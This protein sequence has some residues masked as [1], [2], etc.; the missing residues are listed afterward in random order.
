MKILMVCLGNICRSPLAQ[1]IME[2]IIASRKL[3]WTV[4]S[5]GTSGWHNGEQ[6]DVRAMAVAKRHGIDIS[7]QRSRKMTSKDLTVFDIILTMD[8][9]NYN[10]VL[11]IYANSETRHK[12]HLI[13]N[14]SEPNKNLAVPDPYYDGRFEDVFLLLQKTMEDVVHHLSVQEAV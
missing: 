9:Q 10:D 3:D 4:D 12:V 11:Q 2:E 1:G 6:P 13:R 14:L 7:G 8:S 5:A